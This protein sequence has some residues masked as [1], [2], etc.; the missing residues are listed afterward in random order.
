MIGQ[1]GQ[2]GDFEQR[3]PDVLPRPDAGV[4]VFEDLE[5]FL[6]DLGERCGELRDD[7]RDELG[8]DLL[9]FFGEGG[10]MRA[11]KEVEV[12][13]FFSESARS[14]MLFR[15][16]QRCLHFLTCSSCSSFVSARRVRMRSRDSTSAAAAAAGEGVAILRKKR[17]RERKGFRERSGQTIE[18]KWLFS[19]FSF[20]PSLPLFSLLPLTYNFFCYT[21]IRLLT[22][23]SRHAHPSSSLFLAASA[24][25]NPEG[26]GKTI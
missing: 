6:L 8:E 21:T 9:L 12:E 19:V 4:D 14:M 20:L 5:A 13:S 23:P 1:A 16:C 10:K 26:G 18:K 3:K 15:C 7:E 17:A 11:G 2:R 22:Q 24:S 25:L